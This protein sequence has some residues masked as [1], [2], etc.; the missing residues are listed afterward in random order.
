MHALVGSVNTCTRQT[1][2]TVIKQSSG[3][4][5]SDD[6]SGGGD[7]DG[8]SDDALLSHAFIC[9]GQGKRVIQKLPSTNDSMTENYSKS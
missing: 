4:D 5:H 9:K 7:K 1:R 8:D 6:G 3:A 2:E